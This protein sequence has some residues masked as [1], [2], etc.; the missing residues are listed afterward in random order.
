M[1]AFCHE[2]CWYH[3]PDLRDNHALEGYGFEAPRIYAGW[4]VKKA[5]K[6]RWET[7]TVIRDGSDIV[8]HCPPAIFRF[9]HVGKILEVKGDTSLVTQRL[10]RC[11]KYHFP[12]VV[13]DALLK[14]ENERDIK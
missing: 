1:A 2:C 11:V 9:C 14:Y 12:E 13:Y 10:L 4:H 6:E 5:L 7:F 8:T 3:R